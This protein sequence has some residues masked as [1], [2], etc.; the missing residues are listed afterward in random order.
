MSGTYKKDYLKEI[1]SFLNDIE[2]NS[3][4]TLPNIECKENEINLSSQSLFKELY[5]NLILYYKINNKRKIETNEQ[6]YFYSALFDVLNIIYNSKSDIFYLNPEIKLTLIYLIDFF[7]EEKIINLEILCKIFF[8]LK[9]IIENLTINKIDAKVF[10]FETNLYETIKIC[11]DNYVSE[12]EIQIENTKLNNFNNMIACINSLEKKSLPILLKGFLKYNKKK[13]QEKLIIIKIYE[14]IKEINPYKSN[15]NNINF[16]LYQGY[17]LYEIFRYRKD[18]KSRINIKGFYNIKNNR[19]KNFYAKEILKLSI[20]FLQKKTLKDLLDEIENEKIETE[21]EC[22]KISDNFD[23]TEEYYKDLY[24]Q[25]KFYLIEYK[26]DKKESKYKTCKIILYDFYRVLWLNFCKILL[27]NLTQEDIEKKYIKIIFFFIASL[28]NYKNDYNLSLIFR[29]DTIPIFYS[30]IK[31]KDLLLSYHYILRTLDKEYSQYYSKA[32]DEIIFNQKSIDLI[33]EK[34]LSNP[35]VEDFLK[36]N[37]NKI[38][39]YEL[40]NIFKYSPNFPLPLL[41]HYLAE[42]EQIEINDIKELSHF[43]FY[44]MCFCDLEKEEQNSFFENIESI[45]LIETETNKEKNED[46]IKEIIKSDEFINLIKKIMS[47]TVMNNVYYF[48]DKFYSS[49]GKMSLEEE[50]EI[51]KNKEKINLYEE[52][53]I[54]DD[55]SNIEIFRINNEKKP[56]YNESNNNE[57]REKEKEINNNNSLNNNDDINIKSKLANNLINQK[58]IIYYYKKFCAELEKFDYSNIFIIMGL[59]KEIKGFTF[60]FLKIV[61]N[62]KGIE[63]LSKNDIEKIVLLKAY[64]IFVII[65]E[66]NHFIKRYYNKNVKSNL[67]DTPK[68]QEYDEGGKHLIKIIF[69]DELINKNLNL[70]QAYFITDINNWSKSIYE[71]KTEFLNIKKNEGKASIAYLSSDYSSFCDHSLLHA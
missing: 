11:F 12:N 30:Q 14:Y 59:P 51:T 19:I 65:H 37:N 49:N 42:N 70:D 58:P 16:H 69:G 20:K 47:S 17:A 41:K 68:I 36:N 54:N 4:I 43:N 7:K 61:L 21:F 6:K 23:E 8:S 64:L 53:H 33:N 32:F 55:L 26:A 25:L 60:R 10:E 57:K 2:K 31:I 63:L 13:I 24:E 3:N 15:K 44:R 48:I 9:D 1:F 29:K 66:E 46:L 39:K 67:C 5:S 35:N 50:M 28:F 34:I 38:N 52:K 45:N 40:D 27:L 62:S 56:K 71:F 22:L 18:C